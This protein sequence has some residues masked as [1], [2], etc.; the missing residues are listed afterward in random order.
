M[1][2]KAQIIEEVIVIV[3]PCLIETIFI[4]KV[5][6]LKETTAGHITTTAEGVPEE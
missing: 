2:E 3:F 6:T 5:K 1:V 4:A